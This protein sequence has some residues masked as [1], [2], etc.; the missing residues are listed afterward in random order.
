MRGLVERSRWLALIGVVSSLVA[1]AASFVW[2]AIETASAL[3]LLWR[4]QGHDPFIRIAMIQSMDAFL[5]AV[6]LLI[7]GFGL[8]ELFIARLSLPGWLVLG[9]LHDLKSRLASVIVLVL[10]VTF[11]ERF[12][13]GGQPLQL[14]A[15]AASTT[16]V[17]GLLIAFSWFG[18]KET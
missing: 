17:G 3:H 10:C 6:G 4:T 11:L 8:Y 1:A 9:S 5:V 14:L 7:F 15:G 2:G 13:D 16:L 12:V 18:K